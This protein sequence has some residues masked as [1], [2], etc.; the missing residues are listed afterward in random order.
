[1]TTVVMAGIA[2]NMGVES[3]ARGA[4]DRRYALVFA[5]DAISSVTEA[6]HR[7]STETLFPMMGKVRSTREILSALES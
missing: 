1:M 7:F 3:T 4:F 6:M 2:T 5:E